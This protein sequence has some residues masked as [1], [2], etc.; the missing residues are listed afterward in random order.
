[1][2]EAT[3]TNSSAN[4]A[5]DGGAQASPSPIIVEVRKK[6]KRKRIKQ[7]RKGRGKLFNQVEESMAELREEGAISDDAQVV[8]LVVREKPRRR[9]G[10]W[11]F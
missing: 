3:K 1:M 9:F 4:T 11:K 2:A 8:V 10:R 6:Q 7:L 5:A